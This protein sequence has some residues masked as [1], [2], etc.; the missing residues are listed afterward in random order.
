MI[1]RPF[2]KSSITPSFL[3]PYV[4]CVIVAVGL[5]VQFGYHLIGFSRKQ[6][7]I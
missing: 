6:R 7:A 4:A 5:L 2:Y 1:L 3:A